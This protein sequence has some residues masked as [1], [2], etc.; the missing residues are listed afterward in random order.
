ML[1]FFQL[2]KKKLNGLTIFGLKGGCTSRASI[3]SQSIRLQI[4]ELANFLLE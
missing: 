4:S 3:F 1:K 2:K